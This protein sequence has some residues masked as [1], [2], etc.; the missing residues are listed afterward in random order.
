MFIMDGN[1]YFWKFIVRLVVCFFF[2][3]FEN[4][5]CFFRGHLFRQYLFFFLYLNMCLNFSGCSGLGW[6]R[7]LGLLRDIWLNTRVTTCAHAIC[8]RSLS[9]IFTKNIL[10]KPAYSTRLQPK[11]LV[12]CVMIM[13]VWCPTHPRPSVIYNFSWVCGNI[14]MPRYILRNSLLSMLQKNRVCFFF[15]LVLTKSICFKLKILKT[16]YTHTH[17]IL[18]KIILEAKKRKNSFAKNKYK[19]GQSV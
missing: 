5:L 15:W 10:R 2:H 6:L 12:M 19:V 16:L 13:P 7:P 8:F 17:N 18:S 11:I 14:Q 3:A 9:E 1:Y 4:C